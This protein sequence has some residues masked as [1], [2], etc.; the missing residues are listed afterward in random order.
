MSDTERIRTFVLANKVL[1]KITVV[2]REFYLF[3]FSNNK[4]IHVVSDMSIDCVKC[5]LPRR[6]TAIKL[7][8]T[9]NLFIRANLEQDL[10]TY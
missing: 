9:G 1:N 5:K 8:K 2:Y 4:T 6:T 3:S 10:E 7:N